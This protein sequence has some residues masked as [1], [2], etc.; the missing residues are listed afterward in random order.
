MSS[1]IFHS[2]LHSNYLLILLVVGVIVLGLPHGALDPMVARRYLQ[3]YPTIR[4]P[5]TYFY[6]LYIL[7]ALAYIG[8]WLI[9]PT[10]GLISFLIISAFHFGSDWGSRGSI[11]TRTAY[12][13]TIITLP[14]TF[15][16]AIVSK[17]F[18]VLGAHHL[19]AIIAVS[20]L[21]GP[22]AA[23]VAI[24]AAFVRFKNYKNDFWEICA[25]AAGAMLLNPLIFFILYFCL[26]HSPRHLFET[27]TD[28]GL[29]GTS[30]IFKATAPTVLLTLVAALLAILIMPKVSFSQLALTIV[31]IGLA[32][33]TL[34]HMILEFIAS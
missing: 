19:P 26:L 31:F 14:A 30:A 27:A 18:A 5:M 21:V 23:I 29:K 32:A 13:L 6:V 20:A 4:H 1:L 12:G 17:V 10:I 22:V 9:A 2:T 11:I 24:I 33:L 16:P 15:H 7:I 28:L 34:P 25:I 8:V 3:K